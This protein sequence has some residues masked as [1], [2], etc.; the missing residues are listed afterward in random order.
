MF[1]GTPHLGSKMGNWSSNLSGLGTVLGTSNVAAML[2]MNAPHLV[3]LNSNF[4][5][6]ANRLIIKSIY[7]MRSI[8]G[9]SAGLVV[10]HT[11]GIVYGRDH[12]CQL[13]TYV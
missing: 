1:F 6:L 7:E 13:I 12:D 9:Y 5:L 8:I 11:H 4:A 10:C 3:H 2:R